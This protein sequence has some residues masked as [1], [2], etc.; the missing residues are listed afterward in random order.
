MNERKKPWFD[1]FLDKHPH[2]HQ[3]MSIIAL[4]AEICWII[5]WI[6]NRRKERDN[7]EPFER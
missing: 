7:S 4:L 2:F 3:T 1:R 6:A 5:A